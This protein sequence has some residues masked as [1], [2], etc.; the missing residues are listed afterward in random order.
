MFRSRLNSIL[1][2]ELSSITFKLGISIILFISL[3][4]I[5][6]NIQYPYLWFDEAATFWIS[7]GIKID[8]E[9]LTKVGGIYDV[10]ENNKFLN[11]DPGGFSI[12]LHFWSKINTSPTFLRLLPFLFY[13]GAQIVFILLLNKRLKNIHL[14]MFF[15][16]I[17]FVFPNFYSS[18]YELRAYS[19]ELFSI[20]LTMYLIEMTKDLKNINYRKIYI[21]SVFIS[22]SITS[23]YSTMIFTVIAYGIISYNLLKS[24]FN[25]KSKIAKITFITL[26]ILI[27][28]TSVYIYSYRFQKNF[29][30]K[31]HYLNYLSTDLKTI[32]NLGNLSYILLLVILLKTYIS[33]P[34]KNNLILLTIL[35]NIS[36]IFLSIIDKYP[37]DPISTR[38][39]IIL[40]PVVFCFCTIIGERSK[41]YIEYHWTKRT[42]LLLLVF[43]LNIF[44]YK[45]INKF[46]KPAELYTFLINYNFNDKPK[47]YADRWSNVS[48]RYLYEYGNLKTYKVKHSYPR[49]FKLM[50]SK[51]YLNTINKTIKW[52][53][54]QKQMDQINDYDLVIGPELTHYTSQKNR[55]NWF[56]LNKELSIYKRK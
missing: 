32:M 27:V 35:V 52:Y 19:M 48:I 23:R 11:L 8:A 38:C 20:L 44:S 28:S 53:K 50:N 22:I 24:D 39:N 21:L 26:P 6:L 37:W 9:P 25:F 55:K 7:Q 51:K 17:L 5:S 42:I 1:K 49:N 29:S 3:F 43:I 13:L 56:L 31:L 10:I 16:L 14:S 34:K 33:S 45:L 46:D 2:N 4:L 54:I 18:A 12:L 40:L 30:E 36:F 15:S 41:K 47:I